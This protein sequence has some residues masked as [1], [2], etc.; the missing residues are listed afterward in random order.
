MTQAQ[1]FL[2]CTHRSSAHLGADCA[3]KVSFSHLHINADFLN[4]TGSGQ[5]QG[6]LKNKCVLNINCSP[7]IIKSPDGP[8]WKNKF[9]AVFLSN[10]HLFVPSLSWQTT[11]SFL[12]FH[13]KQVRPAQ[14]NVPLHKLCK[15]TARLK[16]SLSPLPSP[17][18][19]GSSSGR[20]RRKGSLRQTCAWTRRAWLRV[21][22]RCINRSKRHTW[23]RVGFSV[24]FVRS[25]SWQILID[26]IAFVF[27]SW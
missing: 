24:T 8:S 12:F 20:A 13:L 4:K 2:T 6:K 5:T 14:K 21:C 3:K 15:K 16:F 19:R 10:A 27:L 22:A 7:G 26:A 17:A 9:K 25:V 1:R 11:V 23:F 18:P